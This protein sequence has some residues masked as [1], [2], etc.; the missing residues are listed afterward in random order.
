MIRASKAIAVLSGSALL[1]T[2]ACT[3]P[4]HLGGTDP[5]RKAKEGA[6]LG[7][8]LGAISGAMVSKDEKKGAIV[9]AAIGA[10]VG[11]AIGNNLDK[12]EAEL[13]QDLDGNVGI[14]NTGDRLIVTM[15]QDI[16]F[17]TDSTYVQSGL[18]DDIQTVA[19]SLNRYPDT[20]VQVVG[21]TDNTGS[22]AYN[23]DLSQRRAGAVADILISAG[24][25]AGRVQTIGRGEDAPIASNLE[26]SG[27][28]QNRRV[29]IVILPN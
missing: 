8:F 5:N 17:A 3:S 7:G 19:L 26:A 24:V 13:R 14:Q 1:L 11:A 18:R 25:R 2:T 23:Q 22:A 15:P 20:T 4:E 6:L 16:L 21:H 28:A 29:E 10:G 9:G 27:R 12:Q